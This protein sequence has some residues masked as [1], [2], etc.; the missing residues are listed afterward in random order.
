MLSSLAAR[1]VDGAA[2]ADALAVK[3]CKLRRGR[4]SVYTLQRKLVLIEDAVVNP[5]IR[6]CGYEYVQKDRHAHTS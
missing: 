4:Q 6:R 3:P 5:Y 2:R 1:D